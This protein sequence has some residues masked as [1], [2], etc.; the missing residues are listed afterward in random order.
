MTQNIQRKKVKNET[1]YTVND[2][3]IAAI[4]T[5]GMLL[6]A[7]SLVV[8][9]GERRMLDKLA[10]KAKARDGVAGIRELP[11]HVMQLQN[12]EVVIRRP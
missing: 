3:I 11:G 2:E 5:D 6:V 10:V 7:T 9:R 4:D 1:Y 12:G 8:E